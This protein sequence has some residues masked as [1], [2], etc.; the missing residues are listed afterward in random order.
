MPPP[1]IAAPL[2]RLISRLSRHSLLKD[3]ARDAAV[4]LKLR[5][6]FWSAKQLIVGGDTGARFMLILS[7]MVSSFEETRS[8][9]RQIVALH[10][11]GDLANVA[12]SPAPEGDLQLEA[13][14]DSWV[15]EIAVADLKTRLLEP[16]ALAGVLWREA[17]H[18]AR[19]L[20]KWVANRGRKS[21]I[22]RLAHLLC[23][24]ACRH[25]QTASP[26]ILAFDLSMTQQQLADALAMTAVHVNR[27]LQKLRREKVIRTHHRLIEI[28]DWNALTSI[29]EFDPRYLGWPVLG[30]R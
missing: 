18:D 10:L 19:V 16:S 14:T 2:D 8:G 3:K 29:G 28:L 24:L 4:G 17:S 25:E 12:T 30:K 26:S 5:P 15:V 11:P 21:A 20:A 9:Q 7:G 23:E 13:L 27:E 22:S 6:H 1:D